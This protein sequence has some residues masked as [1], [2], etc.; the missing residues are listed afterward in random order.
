VNK[1]PLPIY[2]DSD[3]FYLLSKNKLLKSYPKLQPLVSIIQASYAQYLAV[4][5][6]PTLV[7]NEPI[8]FAE[9]E[10]LKGHYASP[11]AVLAHITKMRHLRR[12]FTCPMCGSFHIS[13]LDHYLPK[14]GYPIFAIFSKNLV[15]ACSCN[16][17]RQQTLIG[18]NPKERVL[19]PYFDEC[20]SERLIKACFEDLGPVP[21]VSIALNVPATHPQYAA[22]DFHMRSIVARSDIVQHLAKRWSS[23]IRKPSLVVRAFEKNISTVVEVESILQKELSEL[24]DLYEGKNNWDSVF[25]AGLTE[26]P[27]AAWIAAQLAVPGRIPNSALA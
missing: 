19:H 27:V 11:P 18:A 14:N 2:D 1:A 15:P 13:E 7:I 9:A 17:K 26:P 16:N 5:G 10:F 8:G 24:D 3:A 4:S 22:I 21:R 12:Q 6:E 20:L 25:A 23:L